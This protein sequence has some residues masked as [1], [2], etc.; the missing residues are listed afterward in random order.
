VPIVMGTI[1]LVPVLLLLSPA[2][3]EK[4]ETPANK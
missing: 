3:M 2:I 1:L 4:K